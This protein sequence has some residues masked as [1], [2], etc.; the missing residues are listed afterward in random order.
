M[1]GNVGRPELWQ[2]VAGWRRLWSDWGL[3]GCEVKRGEA[4]GTWLLWR[5][6]KFKQNFGAGTG[7]GDHLV[8]PA[9]D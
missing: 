6:G 2:S 5:I 9:I 8:N 4:G 7:A 3:L 1:D